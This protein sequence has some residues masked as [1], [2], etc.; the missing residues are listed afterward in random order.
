[1]RS[2]IFYI[3]LIILYWEFWLIFKIEIEI[4]FIETIENNKLKDEIVWRVLLLKNGNVKNILKTEEIILKK[5][6]ISY[7]IINI[8]FKVYVSH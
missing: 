6:I 8:I 2:I 4:N 7:I 1:M 3:Y 5:V